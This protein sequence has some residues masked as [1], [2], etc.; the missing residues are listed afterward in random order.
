MSPAMT[1]RVLGFRVWAERD[2]R[3]HVQD[4][5]G[6]SSRF[7][8]MQFPGQVRHQI[9][10]ARDVKA[11]LS[12]AASSAHAPSPGKE[13]VPRPQGMPW[14]PSSRARS[15][16]AACG[17]LC[18]RE[19]EH[20]FMPVAQGLLPFSLLLFLLF[21]LKREKGMTTEMMRECAPEAAQAERPP[22]CLPHRRKFRS[23][24]WLD[25]ALKTADPW[26][27]T[28]ISCPRPRHRHRRRPRPAIP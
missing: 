7:E 6:K 1:W 21:L 14:P 18:A 26:H 17:P 11:P 22:N 4:E 23:A 19:A 16:C 15:A 25:V 20:A 2:K 12:A 27:R 9:P 24:W 28:S 10:Y 8:A 5:V 13:S 3:T